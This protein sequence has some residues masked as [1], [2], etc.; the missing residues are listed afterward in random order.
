MLQAW[1]RNEVTIEQTGFDTRLSG[2][3]Q[4]WLQEADLFVVGLERRYE[5]GFRA[6][7]VTVAEN[8]WKAGRKV[9]VVGSECSADQ[10]SSPFYWDIGSEQPLLNAISEVLKRSIPVPSER[11]HLQKHFENQLK[12]STGH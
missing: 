11:T 10:L 12:I 2:V 3:W 5:K 9:L 7:G 1:T 8:L 6:E 4:R